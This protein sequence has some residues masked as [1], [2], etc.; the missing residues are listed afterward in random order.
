M[1]Q[2]CATEPEFEDMDESKLGKKRNDV[3]FYTFEAL[4][5]VLVE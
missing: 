2:T 4:V 3:T 1:S 5:I